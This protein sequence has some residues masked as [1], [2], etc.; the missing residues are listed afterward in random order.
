MREKIYIYSLVA[1]LLF[2]GLYGDLAYIPTSNSTLYVI[3]TETNQIVAGPISIGSGTIG[4][5]A[6]LNSEKVYTTNF[7][8]NTVSAINTA[9][10]EVV[11]SIYVNPQPYAAAITPDGFAYVSEASSQNVTVINTN[12]NTILGSP[13]LLSGQGSGIAITPDGLYAYV[14]TSPNL[15]TVIDTTTKMVV[16]SIMLPS[17]A[18]YLAITPDGQYVYVPCQNSDAVVVIETNMY[19]I[20]DSIP[21]DNGPTVIAITPNGL[22]AYVGNYETVSVIDLMTNMVVGDPIPVGETSSIA[23]TMD[24]KY[25]YLPNRNNTITV[26]NTSTNLVESSVAFPGF[27]TSIVMVDGQAI[28][29]PPTNL[30]GIQQKNDFGTLY[31]WVNCLNWRKSPSVRVGG[32]YVY[33]SGTKI[34]TLSGHTTEYEDHNRQRGVATEYSVSAFNLDG[35]EST[36]I[37]VVVE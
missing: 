26:I 17:S 14:V 13:I 35:T 28:I 9:T 19:S 30:Q 1:N 11:A 7:T 8:N 34:A 33:R 32:Y 20:V 37:S 31:E 27:G 6:T 16:A 3:D 5:A 10:N 2:C 23:I 36:L 22:Y 18:A 24:G 21:I 29:A 25:A 12:T 15:V 4:V